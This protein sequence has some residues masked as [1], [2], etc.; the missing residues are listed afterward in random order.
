MWWYKEL[1]LYIL[2][3]WYNVLSCGIKCHVGEQFSG[4]R[5][6]VFCCI[7]YLDL[8]QICEGGYTE[9]CLCCAIKCYVVVKSVMLWYKVICCGI[10][11]YV[12]V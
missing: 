7:K 6:Y 4:S 11:C 12:V 2:M 1:Y 10:K 5:S 9:Q 3:L 8:V